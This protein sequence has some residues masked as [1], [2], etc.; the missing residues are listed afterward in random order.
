MK[1]RLLGVLLFGSGFLFAQT[2]IGLGY[3]YTDYD[4]SKTKIDGKTYDAE[5]RHRFDE[6][7]FTFHYENS[8]ADRIGTNPTLEIDKISLLYR[9]DITTDVSLKGSYLTIND[10][11]APT[12]DGKVYGL[13]F[14]YKFN[15]K[16]VGMVDY[17]HSDY[18]AFDVAQVDI[19]LSQIFKIGDVVSKVMLSA[20]KIDIDGT[21]YGNY[22]FKDKDY[23]TY[24]INVSANYNGY[25]ATIGTMVGKRLF[26]VLEEGMRVQHHAVEQDKSYAL[27]FGK[28]FKS[29]DVFVKYAYQNGDELSENR[30][31]VDT[32]TTSLNII[33]KF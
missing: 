31:D 24:G 12:D 19:S 29:S 28:K 9:Y 5:M 8:S 22:G 27:S 15:E 13:G 17:Y 14:G 16:L 23:T 25:I 32:K 21:R 30:K 1:K 6:S 3:G 26:A 7:L 10:N 4:N 20:K 33:Y 11:I 2:D 18:K